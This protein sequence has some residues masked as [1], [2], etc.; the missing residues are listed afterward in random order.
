VFDPYLN[1]SWFTG[2]YD[3]DLVDSPSVANCF[4]IAARK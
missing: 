3:L 2:N 4:I 1:P